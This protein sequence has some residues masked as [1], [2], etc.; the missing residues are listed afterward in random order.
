MQDHTASPNAPGAPEIPYGYCHCG[1]GQ[2]TSITRQ[3]YPEFGT[4]KGDPYHYATGHRRGSRMRENALDRFMQRIDRSGGDESCWEWT[5]GKSSRGYGTITVGG[6]NLGAH[7]F[8]FENFV[9]PIPD[10][11]YV[12]HKCDNPACC[13]PS[14]LFLGTALDNNRDRN[15]KGRANRAVGERARHAL[16]TSEE[17]LE[18]RRTYRQGSSDFNQPALALRFGVSQSTISDIVL[19]KKWKH[20]LTEAGVA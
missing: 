13:N 10:G 7:R 18:I 9:G 17:V 16:L 15:S 1:C 12:C 4:T 14:H 6:V 3:D 2:K 8:A 5:A 11:M 20:L 19:G